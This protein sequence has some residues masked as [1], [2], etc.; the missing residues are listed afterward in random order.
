[1]L[2]M[3][4]DWPSNAWPGRGQPGPGGWSLREDYMPPI[5]FIGV[6]VHV[7]CGAGVQVGCGAGVQVGCG[8]GVH[9]D[10]G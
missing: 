5:E 8:A 4:A 7:G 1:M 6:G 3:A 9:V 2:Q 10:C